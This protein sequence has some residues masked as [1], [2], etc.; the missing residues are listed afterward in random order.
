MEYDHYSVA[1]KDNPGRQEGGKR[2]WSEQRDNWSRPSDRVDSRRRSRGVVWL[3]L[4]DVC[5]CYSISG[6]IVRVGEQVLYQNCGGDDN[7]NC[8]QSCHLIILFH[9]Y[10]CQGGLDSVELSELPCDGFLYFFH[11]LGFYLRN[12]IINAIDL[13]DLLHAF[14]FSQIVNKRILASKFGIHKNKS[15]WHG[16]LIM[17]DV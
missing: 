14:E 16:M 1:A 17:S 6:C 8:R 5:P 15:F 13:I 3:L 4:G 9:D 11:R 2:A 12:N 10:H 7:N